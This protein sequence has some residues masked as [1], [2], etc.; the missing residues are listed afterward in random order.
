MAER[1]YRAWVAKTMEERTD[2][3]T[4]EE[5]RKWALETRN[6]YGTPEAGYYFD[7]DQEGDERE[8]D[9]D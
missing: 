1:Y 4:P 9:D 8:G 5:A 7:I 3:D 2:F 6:K